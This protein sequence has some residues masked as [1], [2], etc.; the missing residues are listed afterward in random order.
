MNG[1][2]SREQL[3]SLVAYGALRTFP[4]NT[5]IITEG[6]Q[7]D[8][9]YVVVSGKLKVFLADSSGKEINV[10]T[11]GPNDYFGEMALDGK[12][13][14]ASVVT[15]ETSQ[16]SMVQGPDF[17]RFLAENPDA[18]YALILRLI[19]RARHLTRAIGSLALLDVYGRVA[20]LLLD[21]ARETDGRFVVMDRM[22]HQE[23]ATRVN[24]SRETV[25]R[26]LTDLRD[27]DYISIDQDHIIIRRPLPHR[28]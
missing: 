21:S 19:H 2:F 15:L 10:D 9:V 22:T 18:S 8:Q 23:L 26:I 20:R 17:K 14:S 1:G 27:G 13:R 7:N 12:P 3:K 25:S 11:L 28:W 6:D 4:K 24:C 5:F 16:L